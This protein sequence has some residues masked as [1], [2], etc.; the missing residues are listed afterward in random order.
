M[1][2]CPKCRVEVPANARFCGN[3]GY[4]PGTPATSQVQPH[5]PSVVPSIASIPTRS[6]QSVAKR[7]PTRPHPAQSAGSQVPN[8]R[9]PAPPSNQQEKQQSAPAGLIRPVGATP[10]KEPTLSTPP[11]QANKDDLIP[12][13][14][15]PAHILALTAVTPPSTLMLPPQTQT[16]MLN[17]PRPQQFRP[18]FIPATEPR[19]LREQ[20]LEPIQVG[21][22][23]VQQGQ[24]AQR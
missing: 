1:Y 10:S 17:G 14:S 3:C 4:K 11:E 2:F 19:E 8:T 21:E 12:L 16:P 7:I 18:Y 20:K 13:Q 24:S 5:T 23:L 6:V 22:Q 9:K 15:T